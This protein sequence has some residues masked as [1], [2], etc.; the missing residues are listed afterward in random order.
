MASFHSFFENNV[1][2]IDEKVRAFR[3][4]NAY[5]VY[6]EGGIEI[7]G[8]QEVLPWYRALLR[9]FVSKSMLPFSLEILADDGAKL[10]SIHRGF[11]FAFSK[12]TIKDGTGTELAKINQKFSMLKPKFHLLDPAGNQI[13]TIQG[14]WKA[15]NFQITDKDE[16]VIG[17]I[18]KK[19]NGALKEVFTTADKYIVSINPEVA[20][21]T[22]KVAIVAAAITIDMILKEG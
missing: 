11:T 17:T 21:D 12:V 1:F 4:S 22:Q 5:R 3:M 7:G 9:V 14:D 8:I 15:W 2:V 6:N 19:W 18:N 10:A 13:G 16:Q 20:E